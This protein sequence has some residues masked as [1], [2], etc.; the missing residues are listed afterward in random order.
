VDWSRIKTIFIITFLILDVFLGYQYVQKRSS[1]Q[2]DVALEMS[3]ED[4]LQAD[5]ITYIE[6]P[7]K[8]IK[9]NY[10]SGKRKKFTHDDIKKLQ[11]QTVVMV[12][13]MSLKSTLIKPVSMPEINV[14]YRLNQFV[15]D[16]VILGD[17][18]VYW[19]YKKE[20]KSYY[21]YQQYKEKTIYNNYS[22]MLVIHV[23]EDNQI[24]SYDQTLLNEIEE[25]KRKEDIIPAIKALEILYKKDLL[26][27]G[28]HVTNVDL[29]YYGL[30]L[31]NSSKSYVLTPT[32]R[33]VVD[34]KEDYYVNAL[35]GQVI[36]ENQ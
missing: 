1:Y 3:I 10:I 12:D 5:E 35:E 2:I 20:T 17:T 27:Q 11:N 16:N 6:L 19:N 18:Y 31:F 13:P 30:F 8:E 34:N 24:V 15:K 25:Y 33:I 22:A 26:E 4:Q 14:E 23:N 36:D 9:E 28:T 32:W 29:G 21:F 7:K